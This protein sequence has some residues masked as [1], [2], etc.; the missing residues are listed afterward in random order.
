MGPGSG[1][2][3]H[4]YS[5]Q[6][7]ISLHYKTMDIGLVHLMMCLFFPSFYWYSWKYGHWPGQVYVSGSGWSH[8]MMVYLPMVC[9]LLVPTMPKVSSKPNHHE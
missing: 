6:S 9:L 8:T 7:D 5:C 2:V 3:H 4:F 1:A